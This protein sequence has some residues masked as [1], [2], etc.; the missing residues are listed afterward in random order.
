MVEASGY[1]AMASWP[2]RFLAS[3][4][5]LFVR[6]LRWRVTVVGLE[7]LP[8]SGGAVLTWNHTAHADFIMAGWGLR[9][10]KRLPRF[11]A[12][13]ELW[14][15]KVSRAVVTAVGAVPVDR[16]S[17]EGRAQSFAA[18]V[19][20]LRGGAIV[21]VAPEG[22][23][24]SSFELLPFRG[25]ATRMAQEAGVPIIP[26]V[27][28]GSHRLVTYGHK[29]SPRRAWRIPVTVRYGEPMHVGPDDDVL[30]ATERLRRTMQRLLH[31]VQ[32]RYPD[33][34]PAG[35]WWVP[36]RLGGGAPPP[37]ADQEPIVTEPGP[38]DD[39]PL[40]LLEPD[41]AGDECHE[42]DR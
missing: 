31:E 7:H 5:V 13:R 12:K 20:A 25:G 28:W 15:S 32:E 35:A 1:G 39:P 2:Y 42:A 10:V 24:S 16:H 30:E 3:L 9:R 27:T 17:G 38:S 18:A 6:L 26:C 23:I 8:R 4:T 11:L 14:G 33:G 29:F 36:S 34:N 41:D 21:A 37:E 19:D 40:V 22:T